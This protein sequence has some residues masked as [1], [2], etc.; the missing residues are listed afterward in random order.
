MVYGGSFCPVHAGHVMVGGYVGQFVPG[1][2]EV[3]FMLSAR[4]PLKPPYPMTDEERMALLS[5]AV[6]PYPFMR[7]CDLELSMP[8]PSYTVDTLRRLA[9]DHPAYRFRLLVGSDN[10]AG[11][12]RWRCPDEILSEFGILVYPRPGYP[13]DPSSLPAGA[14]YLAGAPEIEISSTF[15]RRGLANGRDMRPF[16]PCLTPRKEEAPGCHLVTR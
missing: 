5:R 3:W 2:D 12:P 7:A 1:V 14:E 13:V 11:L 9:S 10:L 8:R 16:M 6:A 4:N 15:I